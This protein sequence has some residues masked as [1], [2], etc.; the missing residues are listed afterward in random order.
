MKNLI[1]PCFILLMAL[2]YSCDEQPVTAT[3]SCGFHIDIIS[4]SDSGS[5]YLGKFTY[6]IRQVNWMLSYDTV[7]VQSLGFTYKGID[8]SEESLD[9]HPYVV[10]QKG[11]LICIFFKGRTPEQ[12]F[13]VNDGTSRQDF[14]RPHEAFVT[15]YENYFGYTN[16]MGYAEGAGRVKYFPVK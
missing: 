9:Y 11:N 6:D 3:G 13:G 7:P 5:T 1:A 16:E 2:L 15:N 8:F 12:R 14:L 10:F 4:G